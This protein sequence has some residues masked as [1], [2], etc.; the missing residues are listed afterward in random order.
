M[1]QSEYFLEGFPKFWIEDCVDERVHAA[2]DVAQPGRDD[3]GSITWSPRQLKFY[4]HRIQYIASE[5]WHPTDEKAAWKKV[6]KFLN[7]IG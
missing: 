5:K 2:I 6:R 3:E 7:L 1:A 4:A